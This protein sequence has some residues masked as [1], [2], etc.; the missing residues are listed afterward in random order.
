MAAAETRTSSAAPSAEWW[1]LCTMPPDATIATGLIEAPT[2][3]PM[4]GRSPRRR[5]PVMV[6]AAGFQLL[7]TPVF[8][9][10]MMASL[11]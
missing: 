8:V 10:P 7:T 1:V 6:S 5:T 9:V 3:S 11:T 4:G 2:G